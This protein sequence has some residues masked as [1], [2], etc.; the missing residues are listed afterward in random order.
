MSCKCFVPRAI[1]GTITPANLELLMDNLV[2]TIIISGGNGH[3]KMHLAGV[4]VYI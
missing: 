2:Y 4:K 1:R 3:S